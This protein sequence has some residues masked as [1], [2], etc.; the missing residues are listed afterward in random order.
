MSLSQIIMYQNIGHE[1]KYGKQEKKIKTAQEMSYE[2]LKKARDE[3]RRLYG[4]IGGD[5]GN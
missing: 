1:L 4:D 2:E 3:A 5:N